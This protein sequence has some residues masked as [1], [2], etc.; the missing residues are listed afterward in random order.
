MD[1]LNNKLKEIA[2]NQLYDSYSTVK[3][4]SFN[5]QHPIF[6]TLMKLEFEKCIRSYLQ[7][8]NSLI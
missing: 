6:K 2:R 8:I 4:T 3:K 5:N 7:D 1:S